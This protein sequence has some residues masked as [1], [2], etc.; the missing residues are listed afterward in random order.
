MAWITFPTGTCSS[1]VLRKRMNSWWRWRC[2]VAADDGAIEDVEGCEQRGG[3]VTFVVVR[4]RPGTARLHR[5]SR[6]GAVECLDLAFLVD[7][8]N[9][10]IGGRIDVEADDVFELLGELR[11]RRQ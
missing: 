4:H 7:R 1:I 11:V 8:E 10:R 3:A 6:L 5:Q 2:I 9:N